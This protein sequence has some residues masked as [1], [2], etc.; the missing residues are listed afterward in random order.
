MR[1]NK[2][3]GPSSSQNNLMTST[4]RDISQY[5]PRY[6]NMT[7][8]LKQTIETPQDFENTHANLLLDLDF[9][10]TEMVKKGF[11]YSTPQIVIMDVNS[12][13]YVRLAFFKLK[14]FYKSQIIQQQEMFERVKQQLNGDNEVIK[15]QVDILKKNEEALQIETKQ[16][17]DALAKTQHEKERVISKLR[18]LETDL[19]KQR[20]ESKKRYDELYQRFVKVDLE[21]S[22]EK[23]KRVSNVALIQTSTTPLP[24]QTIEMKDEMVKK[25]REIE[26]LKGD[27]QRL[28]CKMF[29]ISKLS[30]LFQE[31]C[32]QEKGW[33]EKN[34]TKTLFESTT[35]EFD[36][37][38]FFE[39]VRGKEDVAVIAFTSKGDVFGGFYH[40]PVHVHNKESYDQNIFLFSFESNGRLHGPQHFKVSTSK[41][42]QVFV[43]VFDKGGLFV[44]FGSE[45]GSLGFGPEKGTPHSFCCNVERVFDGLAN[46]DLTGSFSTMADEQTFFVVRVVALQLL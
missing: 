1:A 10:K 33:T 13:D 12:A 37:H 15:Q 29:D 25:D 3:K 16:L 43:R 8:F 27:L 4:S 32:F 20:G 18:L 24:V 46:T 40:I 23:E 45:N 7:S 14:D 39:S 9:K 21:L 26:L 19:E 34:T 17:T 38:H 44:W 42:N 6:L 11:K 30:P 22:E 28:R 35:N 41:R 5:D 36:A 31:W 2:K